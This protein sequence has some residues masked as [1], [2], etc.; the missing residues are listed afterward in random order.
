MLWIIDLDRRTADVYRSADAR[1]MIT[2]H[3]HLDGPGFRLKLADL[4]DAADFS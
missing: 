1:Q 3:D 2:E 4:L